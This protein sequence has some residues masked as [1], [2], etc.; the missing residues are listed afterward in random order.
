MMESPEGAL[1]QEKADRQFKLTAVAEKFNACRGVVAEQYGVINVYKVAEYFYFTL[2]H[3]EEFEGIEV[4]ENP[5]FPNR[6]ANLKKPTSISAEEFP[7]KDEFIKK[8]RHAMTQETAFDEALFPGALEELEK[9][10]EMGPV[11]IWTK[12]DNA[13]LTIDEEKLPGSAEQLKKTAK[14]GLNEL[15]KK[16]ASKTGKTK[17]EILRVTAAENK[18]EIIPEMLKQFSE[19]GISRVIVLEDNLKNL[20]AF[21]DEA[22]KHEDIKVTPIWVR[23][24]ARKNKFPKEPAKSEE[25]WEREYNAIDSITETVQK[26]KELGISNENELLGFIVDYDDVLSDDRKKQAKQAAAVLQALESKGWI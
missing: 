15:R 16:I 12:G 6:S 23:Q 5:K 22:G 26:I 17:Q 18:K 2:Y 14:A 13:G 24:G 20:V 8:I 19:K 11:N 3:P 4:P 25:E 10:M 9:M 1:S 21:V 7:N